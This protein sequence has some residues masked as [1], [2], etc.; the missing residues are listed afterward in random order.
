MIENLN[1]KVTVISFYKLLLWSSFQS[2]PLLKQDA[3]CWE[4]TAGVGPLKRMCHVHNRRDCVWQ[5]RY[6]SLFLRA[7]VSE[8]VLSPSITLEIEVIS[9]PSVKGLRSFDIQPDPCWLSGTLQPRDSD[10]GSF[11]G[12]VFSS[13]QV[14]EV[15]VLCFLIAN[16]SAV[17]KFEIKYLGDISGIKCKSQVLELEILSAFHK[18]IWK[19]ICLIF[20]WDKSCLGFVLVCI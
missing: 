15:T 10:V 13:W 16:S 18:L 12:G 4:Q 20:N 1:F 8:Y 7:C 6:F 5:S 14:A 11:S 9:L 17:G 3:D 2:T 19:L